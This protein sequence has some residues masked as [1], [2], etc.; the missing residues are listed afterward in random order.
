MPS[1]IQ[2]AQEQSTQPPA[3]WKLPVDNPDMESNALQI[4]VEA[5]TV[6]DWT[7][8]KGCDVQIWS[9]STVID[10]GTV[11]DATYDGEILWLKQDGATTRRLVQ[12]TTNTAVHVLRTN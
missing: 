11:D 12:K 6:S 5:Y 8:L 7:A 4:T 1:G 2:A 10:N 3:R 9:G